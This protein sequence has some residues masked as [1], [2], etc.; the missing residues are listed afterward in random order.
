MVMRKLLS[1]E[2]LRIK[3]N[4]YLWHEQE[5]AIETGYTIDNLYYSFVKLEV[6]TVIHR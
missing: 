1:T 6:F 5:R 3:S 2:L 4:E